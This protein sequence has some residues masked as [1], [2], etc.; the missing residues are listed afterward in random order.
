MQE[1]TAVLSAEELKKQIVESLERQGFIVQGSRVSLPADIQKDG[2]RILH[3]EAVKHKVST[4]SPLLKRSED[5]FLAR[6]A[7]GSEIVPE[8]I[9]PVLREVE[10]GSEDEALF[11]WA[12]LHW[13]IP[14]SSGYGRRLRFLVF[15]S[16]NGKLMGLF[17]LGDPVFS[18]A[19]RDEWVGWDSQTRRTNLSS[20]LD[21]FVLGAVPPYSLLLCGKL[22]AAL[23]ASNEVRTAFERKYHGRL[24]LILKRKDQGRLAMVTTTSALG[25][26]SVYNRIKFDGRFI[27]ESVGFTHGF[28]EFHF[29][30]GLYGQI[31]QYTRTNCKPSAKKEEWG[32]GFR[33]RREVI[34]KCLCHMGL[35][36]D[37]LQHGVQREIFV[38]PLASNTREFLCGHDAVLQYYDQPAA[39]LSEWFRQ[40]WLL[41]RARRDKSFRD[42]DTNSYRLWPKE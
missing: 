24:S 22:V 35:G 40:R 29:L 26:S 23:V 41:P 37:W 20:V 4:A 27:L 42:F 1:S 6:L 19:A 34:R 28:G 16:S 5:K 12:C 15:D 11:R 7:T 39:T 21:A 13:S 25:R 30:N 14:V 36:D 10:S 18:L 38:A 8:R 17:G 31:L 32:R 9:S 2:L 3:S 33:N